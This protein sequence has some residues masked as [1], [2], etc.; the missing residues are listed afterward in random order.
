ML[1]RTQ[2][3]LLLGT[4]VALWAALLL[5][6]GESLGWR[7]LAPFSS[8]V[9]CSLALLFVFEKWGWKLRVLHSWLVPFQNLSGTWRGTLQTSWEDPRTLQRPVPIQVFLVIRQTY[10]TVS[11][12]VLTAESESDMIVG[13]VVV[14]EGDLA[15]LVG[16]YR[17]TPKQSVRHRSPIHHGA[18]RLRIEGEPV[19]AL[20]GEYWTDR[21]TQGEM[22]LGEHVKALAHGFEHARSLFELPSSSAAASP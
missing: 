3:T 15:D 16:V 14:V 2:L 10:S 13:K 1:T 20:A 8:V 7:H 22:R 4:Q 9:S 6:Q 19:T 11:V 18:F 17:N 5:V 12:R 21:K